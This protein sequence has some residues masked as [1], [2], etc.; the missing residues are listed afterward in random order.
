ML[1]LSKYSIIHQ[2]FEL[3]SWEPPAEINRKQV[4]NKQGYFFLPN[5]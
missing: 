2:V 3:D 4:S 1:D 5:T